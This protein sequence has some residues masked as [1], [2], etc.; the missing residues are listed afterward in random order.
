[1][2]VRIVSF[3]IGGGRSGS[4][5]HY[6]ITRFADVL[7]GTTALDERNSLKGARTRPPRLSAPGSA[8]WSS[9]SEGG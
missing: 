2:S 4:T 3:V 5:L 7:I 1:M 9:I 6:P 8:R